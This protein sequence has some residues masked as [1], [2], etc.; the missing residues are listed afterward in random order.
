MLAI[1][2]L[3][4]KAIGVQASSIAPFFR[5]TLLNGH[6]AVDERDVKAYGEKY[7]SRP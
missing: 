3:A 6:R 4:D 2:G 5:G 7:R 1:Q